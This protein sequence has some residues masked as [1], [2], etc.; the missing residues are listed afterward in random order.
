MGPNPLI[1]SNALDDKEQDKKK[2]KFNFFVSILIMSYKTLYIL[3]FICGYRKR[4]T[5]YMFAS[6][7]KCNI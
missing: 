1:S 3:E 7:D 2:L 5:K 6:F 4:A